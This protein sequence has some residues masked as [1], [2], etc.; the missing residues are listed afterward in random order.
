M[1]GMPGLIHRPDDV[2]VPALVVDILVVPLQ[3]L[4]VSLGAVTVTLR[5]QIPLV[6]DQLMHQ[7]A[8]LVIPLRLGGDNR[9][10]QPARVVVLVDVNLLGLPAVEPAQ[11]DADSERSL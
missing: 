10:D 6:V 5:A 11:T 9:A 3:V 2:A 7:S 8:L 4:V 1:L